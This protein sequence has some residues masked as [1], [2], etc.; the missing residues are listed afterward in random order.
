MEKYPGE[1]FLGTLYTFDQ[2]LTM[3]FGGSREIIGT[4]KLCTAKT[5]QY[6]N[7]KNNLCHL[8]FLACVSCAPEQDVA[9]SDACAEIAATERVNVHAGQSDE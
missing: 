3:D 9:C 6:V 1:D 4:C 5:E 7:C 2:R 8:H